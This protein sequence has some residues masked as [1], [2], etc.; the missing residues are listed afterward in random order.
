MEIMSSTSHATNT[1]AFHG[2]P[3]LPP[4][5]RIK[6]WKA[7]CLPRTDSDHG[8]QYVTVDVVKEDW[9]NEDVV[10]YNENLEGYDDEFEVES[11]DTGYITLRALKR[12]KKRPSNSQTPSNQSNKQSAYLWDAGL[13]LAC[14]ESRDTIT[15]YLAID[16]W[17]QVTEQHHPTDVFDPGSWYNKKFLST[18][19]PHKKDT[20]WR[21]MVVPRSDI[22]CIASS[23]LR[24]LPRS[25]YGMKLLAPFLG[26]SKFTI[27]QDWNIA[28]RFDSSWLVNF[29]HD[30]YKLQ[31]EN[32]PRG[33]LA[34]WVHM[35]LD[36][37]NPA[38]TLWIIDDT[39]RWATVA[40]LEC[41]TVYRDCSAEYVQAD[42]CTLLGETSNRGRCDVG[43]FMSSFAQLVEYDHD[44]E[45]EW[46]EFDGVRHD[47]K[48]LVRKENAILT[49]IPA[50]SQDGE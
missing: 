46:F 10:V 22:F 3:K 44:A 5:L 8:L 29:P 11:D 49:H 35:L 12:T 33:M 17:I 36:D 42:W 18:L 37:V 39:A 6:I 2:F 24:H 28:L 7:A 26:Q 45:W 23:P 32:S 15:E 21:P 48:L 38:P 20:I 14:K 50:E 30:Y 40:G 34:N 1:P 41:G 13:W 43:I 4:E 31:T 47:I 27:T 9:E 16:K 25:L 19:V